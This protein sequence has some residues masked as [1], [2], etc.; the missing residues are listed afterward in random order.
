MLFMT[1]G[2]RRSRRCERLLSLWHASYGYGGRVAGRNKGKLGLLVSI[3][4]LRWCGVGVVNGYGTLAK[5][6]VIAG[7]RGDGAWLRCPAGSS[8][9]QRGRRR[10]QAERCRD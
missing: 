5:R 3:G 2:L 10:F 1:A 9:V 8:G 7:A 4:I 6:A